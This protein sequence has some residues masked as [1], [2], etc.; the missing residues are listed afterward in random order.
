MRVGESVRE[1]EERERGRE[2][3]VGEGVKDKG[4]DRGLGSA[5][6]S[7]EAKWIIEWENDYVS[8]L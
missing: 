3:K 1:R 2:R 8:C 6:E 4:G 5:R 7:V